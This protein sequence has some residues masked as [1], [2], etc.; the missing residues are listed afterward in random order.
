V[1]RRVPIR[2]KEAYK[3]KKGHPSM[4]GTS[5]TGEKES[6]EEGDVFSYLKR[7]EEEKGWK[8][9][10]ISILGRGNRKKGEG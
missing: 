9:E 1:K 7:E 4:G 8:G 2:E 3:R 6:G 10:R 5:N